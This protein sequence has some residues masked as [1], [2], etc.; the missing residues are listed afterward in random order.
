MSEPGE[1]PEYELKPEEPAPPRPKPGDPDWVPPTPII[2]KA[3][4]VD[5]E[6]PVDP[7]VQHN[8]AVSILGYIIF[9]V[10]LIG[11]PHS[12]FARFHAN[13]GLLLFI[14]W[15]LSMIGVV[16]LTFG[17]EFLGPHLEAIKV[18]QLFLGCICYV[19]PIFLV[20]APL[21]LTIMGIIHAANGETKEL[22]LIGHWKLIK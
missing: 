6:V 7:D 11:A 21:A 3:D 12:K 13:Q 18:L 14:V 10:P 20:V 2:E 17:W 5:E 16:V 8:K 4:S 9:L 1:G 19:A 22:P 15:C